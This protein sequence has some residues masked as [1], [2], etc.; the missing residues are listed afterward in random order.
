MK[1]IVALLAAVAVSTVFARVVDTQS[2]E[3]SFSDFE[4]NIADEDA[5]ELAAYDNDAPGF[6]APY[7]FEGYGD[8]YLSLD[9]GDATLWRTNTVEAQ[10]TKSQ[11]K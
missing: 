11:R 8:K 9:T 6:T 4:P 7:N 1:R 2:F 3:T 5:S 10:T